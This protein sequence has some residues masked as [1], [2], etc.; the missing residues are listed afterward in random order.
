[1]WFVHEYNGI[2]QMEGLVWKKDKYIVA[3]Q[4]V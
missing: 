3:D 2:L 1:M 4:G